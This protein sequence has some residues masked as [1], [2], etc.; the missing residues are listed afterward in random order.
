MKKLKEPDY[1]QL[2]SDIRDPKLRGCITSR[3]PAVNSWFSQDAWH[4]GVKIYLQDALGHAA[5]KV[6][7]VKTTDAETQYAR[8]FAAAL[9][10][11]LVLPDYI[12]QQ[13]DNEET[14]QKQAAS[15]GQAG[16]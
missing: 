4:K 2:L 3:I 5:E 7:D 10:L 12:S 8:G 11:L 1:V 13:V 14:K 6:F 15:R 16:Y 9:R